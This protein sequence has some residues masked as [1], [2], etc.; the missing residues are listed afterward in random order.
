MKNK[1]EIQN[2]LT[3]S[4]ERGVFC[5]CHVWMMDHGK[6]EYFIVGNKSVYPH[7]EINDQ[8]TIY[9][10]ASLTK[11]IVTTPLILKLIE[12]NLL[13]LD[14]PIQTILPSFQSVQVT[15]EHLLTHTSGLPADTILPLDSQK[16]Q[17]LE[18]IYRLSSCLEPGKQIVYSDL[19]FILLGEIIETITRKS[20][21]DLSKEW[22]F[23]PMEMEETGYL[24]D[25]TWIQR[26]AP[27]ED[28]P[29]LK[30]VI[31]GTAHDRKCRMMQGVSGHAGVFSTIYDLSH[32]AKM[33]LNGGKYK[34]Q[35]IL[36]PESIALLYQ[37]RTPNVNGNRGIGFINSDPVPITP[38][39]SKRAIMHTGFT[40]TS[41]M[42]DFDLELA[43][44]VLSN[45]IHP[46]RNNPLILEWRNQFYEFLMK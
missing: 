23:V 2:Y 25:Q 26:C 35:T 45:R 3:D 41:I 7:K 30:R 36:Q 4:V 22:L 34:K 39:H 6:S 37:N 42:V 20:L 40:G 8:Q 11:V 21:S 18:A 27:T 13:S 31:R 19:G 44:I 1:L 33:L 15:I 9:D 10:L 43:V 29:L 16:P 5:G 12:K 46:T 28:S 14:Q 38:F 17:I 32:Y 24:P